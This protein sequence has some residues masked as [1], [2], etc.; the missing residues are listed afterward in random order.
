MQ[1]RQR[2]VATCIYVKYGSTDRQNVYI[3]YVV[4]I[5][6]LADESEIPSANEQNLAQVPQR[7]WKSISPPNR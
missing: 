4:T 7:R 1:V 6:D 2:V 3:L 5:T